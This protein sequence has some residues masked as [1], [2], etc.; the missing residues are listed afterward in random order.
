MTDKKETPA[1]L[2]FLRENGMFFP[3]FNRE[4]CVA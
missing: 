4:Q 3:G 2:M 1:Q